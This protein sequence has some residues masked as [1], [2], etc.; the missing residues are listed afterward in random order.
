MTERDAPQDVEDRIDLSDTA[1]GPSRPTGLGMAGWLRWSWRSLTSMRTAL[2]LL[3]ILVLAAIPGS[4]F[5]QR[6]SD[7][8]A[9]NQY[10]EDHPTL[11]PMVDRLHMFEVFGSPWFAAIYLLLFVSLVGCVLPRSYRLVVQ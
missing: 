7:Q 9:V 4:V 2:F 6:S 10:L 11:G 3:L 1:T 8:L 5:P